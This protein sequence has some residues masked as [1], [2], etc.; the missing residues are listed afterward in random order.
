MLYQRYNRVI[1][2][3]EGLSELFWVIGY[4]RKFFSEKIICTTIIVETWKNI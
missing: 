1:G 4:D 3:L 2:L